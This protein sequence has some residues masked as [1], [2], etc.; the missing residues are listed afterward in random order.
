MVILEK[1]CQFW[2]GL[3]CFL[4]S[5]ANIREANPKFKVASQN[6]LYLVDRDHLAKILHF[7]GRKSKQQQKSLKDFL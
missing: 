4:S 2:R 5:K 3:S 6:I 1:R 7:I